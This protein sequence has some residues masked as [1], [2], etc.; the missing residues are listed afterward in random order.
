MHLLHFSILHIVLS[1][2][3]HIADISIKI[4]NSTTFHVNKKKKT[5]NSSTNRLLAFN[6]RSISNML[7][8]NSFVQSEQIY[9]IDNGPSITLIHVDV[10]AKL[11]IDD[12]FHNQIKYLIKKSLPPTI[13]IQLLYVPNNVNRILIICMNV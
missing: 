9:S 10:H 8:L 1:F 3:T 4:N 6:L 11:N 2:T 12:E 5:M 7:H 13:R